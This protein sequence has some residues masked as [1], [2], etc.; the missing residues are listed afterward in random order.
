MQNRNMILVCERCGYD[1][2]PRILGVH[3]K[4]RN[5]KNNELANLEVLCPMCHSLE[6]MR[7]L[8]Q[9]GLF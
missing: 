1:E 3:H 9:G 7:H 2:E 8:P 6:H 4:D 5:R